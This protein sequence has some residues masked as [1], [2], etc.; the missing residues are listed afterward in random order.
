MVAFFLL[1]SVIFGFRTHAA[2][3]FAGTFLTV[4]LLAGVQLVC[5]GLLGEYIGRIYDEVRRRPLYLVHKLHQGVALPEVSEAK[6]AA[7]TTLRVQ[8]TQPA[9]MPA[10]EKIVL[11]RNAA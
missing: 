3:G 9:L 4:L 11:G 10:D 7:E 6:T 1:A 5:T 8:V 2:S